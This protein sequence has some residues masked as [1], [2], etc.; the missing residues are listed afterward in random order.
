MAF[1]SNFFSIVSSQIER[2]IWTSNLRAFESPGLFFSGTT[3]TYINMLFHLGFDF[4]GAFKV[5]F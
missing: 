1:H 3:L 5:Q 2:W 4:R